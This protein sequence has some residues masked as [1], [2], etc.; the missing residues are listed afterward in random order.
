[1]GE[2]VKASQTT[3]VTHDTRRFLSANLTKST[4]L[5]IKKGKLTNRN[6]ANQKKDEDSKSRA[7][8]KIL[9]TFATLE[10]RKESTIL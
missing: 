10:E 9:N 3:H 5:A 6:A 7:N 8:P 1:M 4:Q 2:K